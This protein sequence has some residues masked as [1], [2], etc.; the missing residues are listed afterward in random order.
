MY[1]TGFSQGGYGT[2]A[3]ACYDPARFAAIAPVAGGGD[4]RQAKRLAK[5]A[6]WAFHGAKDTVVPLKA[7]AEMVEAVREEGGQVAFTVYPDCGHGACSDCT[8]RDPRV[9]AWLLAQRA[10]R[11]SGHGGV[12]RGGQVRKPVA[13]R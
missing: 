4:V 8:Y 7:S 6:I 13:Q 11:R 1:L 5:L 3:T 10:R 2:W 9:L 12:G